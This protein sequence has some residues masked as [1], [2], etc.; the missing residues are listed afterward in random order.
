MAA[1]LQEA[2]ADLDADGKAELFLRQAAGGRNWVALVFTPVKG[3]YRYMGELGGYALR[4]LP[5]DRDGRPRV[6][7]GWVCGGKVILIE[8]FKH[9]GSRFELVQRESITGGDGAPEEN[10][11]RL[12]KLFGVRTLRWR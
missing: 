3:G 9:T 10:N 2:K 6:M 1:G 11:L 12:D 5:P 4:T 7:T 8:T